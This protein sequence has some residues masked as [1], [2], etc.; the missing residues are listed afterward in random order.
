MRFLCQCGRRT[1]Q[2]AQF[3]W[4]F[5]ALFLTACS[6]TAPAAEVI[7][8]ILPPELPT[9]T[10]VAA[11][12][13][14]TSL[15]TAIV[16]PAPAATF[17]PRPTT[18]PTL[19]STPIPG[20]E[21]AFIFLRDQQLFR[22][23]L[24]DWSTHPMLMPSAGAIDEPVLSPDGRWLAFQ[25][26]EALKLIALASGE[27]LWSEANKPI[28][29][30]GHVVFSPDSR[31]M[32]YTNKE[33]LYLLDVDSLA[34]RPF[35]TNDWSGFEEDVTTLVV[36]SVES[37][38]A[39]GAWLLVWRGYWEGGEL[40]LAEMATGVVYPF[41]GCM[42]DVS[43]APAGAQFAMAMRYSSYHLCGQ[44]DGV[45]RVEPSPQGVTLQTLYD[46]L[47]EPSEQ[48]WLG[49]AD[50]AWSPDRPLIAFAHVYD[51]DIHAAIQLIAPD[52][53]GQQTL[54]ASADAEF[55]TPLWLDASSQLAFTEWRSGYCVLHTVDL[56]SGA[57]AVRPV[58]SDP[59]RL[60]AVANDHWLILATTL[61][62]GRRQ[63]LLLDRFSETQVALDVGHGG[64]VGWDRA[65]Q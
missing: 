57:D 55:A 34:S 63:L 22:Y 23:D 5:F 20:P 61:P 29:R 54:A 6:P 17:T 58:G 14:A 26:E 33:A 1:H 13:A 50:V 9:A 10:S 39:D 3:I 45:Y 15:P 18:P 24:R 31:Q 59:C 49:P 46:A 7:E 19:T 30:P 36:Y 21:L 41:Q 16:T 43:W 62:S 4:L 56:T 64:F 48:E 47:P 35:L 12:L 28:Y 53:T 44:N 51:T 37:W 25:D 42:P 8:P 27:L 40:E 65:G 52:G 38:S 60:V 11:T 32:A 2:K